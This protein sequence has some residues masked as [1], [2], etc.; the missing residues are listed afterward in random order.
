MPANKLDGN[1][2]EKE[3]NGYLPSLASK[4][5]TNRHEVSL[6]FFFGFEVYFENR[7]MCLV[8]CDV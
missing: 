5:N 3:E 6:M 4:K 1:E 7:V 8:C 2:A